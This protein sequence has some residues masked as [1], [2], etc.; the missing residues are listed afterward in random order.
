MIDFR[1]G[2]WEIAFSPPPKTTPQEGSSSC[3]VGFMVGVLGEGS[4]AGT[5]TVNIYWG[6]IQGTCGVARPGTL[7]AERNRSLP[8]AKNAENVIQKGRLLSLD[9]VIVQN[10]I[11]CGVP[12]A[13]LLTDAVIS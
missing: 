8:R 10:G 3:L 13:A 6:N 2:T 4:V 7:V 9:R 11:D 5:V 12:N 1:S